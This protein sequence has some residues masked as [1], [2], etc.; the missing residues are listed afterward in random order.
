MVLKLHNN[1]EISQC[2][3][4]IDVRGTHFEDNAIV[5]VNG[6]ILP[7][8]KF[9]DWAERNNNNNVFIF[10][11]KEIL[12]IPVNIKDY[13]NFID[14]YRHI[15]EIRYF[16]EFVKCNSE[17]MLDVKD[18]R[19]SWSYKEAFLG[20]QYTFF[21]YISFILK[22]IWFFQDGTVLEMVYTYDP[23]KNP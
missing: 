20:G 23:N 10:R 14:H 11:P 6:T 22:P 1:T 21:K 17:N 3:R 9:N 15:I 4:A 19:S 16:I 7:Y 5:K 13:Y 2:A 18:I 12:Q 8:K